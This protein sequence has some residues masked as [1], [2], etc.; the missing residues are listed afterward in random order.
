MKV[1]MEIVFVLLVIGAGFYL[2]DPDRRKVKCPRHRVPMQETNK[3]IQV[4]TLDGT[5]DCRIRGFDC[6]LCEQERTAAAT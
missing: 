1:A 3:T 6:P 5:T 2:G 4:T